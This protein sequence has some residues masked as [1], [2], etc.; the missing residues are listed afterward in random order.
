MCFTCEMAAYRASP[1][2]ASLTARADGPLGMLTTV[3]LINHQHKSQ[4]KKKLSREETFWIGA[5]GTI[6]FGETST[7]LIVSSGS[8]G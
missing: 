5:E 3:R 1:Q 8:G 4:T 6:P 7:L 2:A